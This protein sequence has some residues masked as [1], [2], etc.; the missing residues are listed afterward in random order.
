[1]WH[2]KVEL[3]DLQEEKKKVTKSASKI[4]K[5]IYGATA[6]AMC[7]GLILALSFK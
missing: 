4:V 7:C 1:M 6:N 3:M 5:T 2:D